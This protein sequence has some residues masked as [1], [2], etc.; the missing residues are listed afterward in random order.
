MDTCSLFGGAGAALT[1][2]RLVRA[3]DTD[4]TSKMVIRY[5]N[6]VEAEEFFHKRIQTDI[7]AP[8]IAVARGI[9]IDIVSNTRETYVNMIKPTFVIPSR[10]LQVCH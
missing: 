1:R 10:L 4:E 8:M 6:Q 7:F 9:T 5:A 2:S 3:D